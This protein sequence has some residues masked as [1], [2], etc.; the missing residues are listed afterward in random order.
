[1]NDVD[2]DKIISVSLG[3]GTT[4][5]ACRAID[6]ASRRDGDAAQWANL[7]RSTGIPIST[8]DVIDDQSAQELNDWA[9]AEGVTDDDETGRVDPV[10]RVDEL[11][12]EIFEADEPARKLEYFVTAQFQAYADVLDAMQWRLAE[13]LAPA[14]LEHPELAVTAYRLFG[15]E[16]FNHPVS[17]EYPELVEE[18]RLEVDGLEAR[19]WLER[20]AA[21]ETSHDTDALDAA[22][23]ILEGGTN[24]PGKR[25][26]LARVLGELQER[27]G[28][29]YDRHIDVEHVERDLADA[30]L[31][32]AWNEK[33]NERTK[34]AVILGVLGLAGHFG[35]AAIEHITEVAGGPVAIGV[36]V[37]FVVVSLVVFYFDDLEGWWE[38]GDRS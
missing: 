33:D 14:P 27:F 34:I 36:L 19:E 35:E 8:G 28:T 12:E 4:Q 24:Y 13:E 2:L 22:T 31:A 15:W 20:V 11:V 17:E 29:T 37:S 26:A 6:Q 38:S 9:E 25:K 16:I 7:L 21:G 5:K 32:P 3:P 23:L 18:T 30:G 1:L 10:E